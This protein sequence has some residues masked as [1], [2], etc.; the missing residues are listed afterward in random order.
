VIADQKIDDYRAVHANREKYNDM[1][2]TQIGSPEKAAKLMVDLVNMPEPPVVLFIGSDAYK[3]ASQKIAT[4]Q[5]NLEKN[6][7]LTLSTDF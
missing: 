4:Q 7:A 5:E 2:G 1:N 3:R 6:K